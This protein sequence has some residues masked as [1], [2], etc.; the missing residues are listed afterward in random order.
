MEK[1]EEY[2]DILFSRIEAQQRR[3]EMLLYERLQVP[4]ISFQ[5]LNTHTERILNIHIHFTHSFEIYMLVYREER[6]RETIVCVCVC[7][8]VFNNLRHT[9]EK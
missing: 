9:F 5:T 6:E 3:E 2:A 8:L 4:L 7:V 1:E